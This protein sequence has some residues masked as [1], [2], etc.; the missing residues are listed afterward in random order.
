MGVIAHTSS[1]IYNTRLYVQYS[2]VHI[3][4]HQFC[5]WQHRS[6]CTTTRIANKL[7]HMSSQ[8]CHLSFHETNNPHSQFY[9]SNTK[10]HTPQQAYLCHQGDLTETFEHSEYHERSHSSPTARFVTFSNILVAL[11]SCA[12]NIPVIH[13][14]GSLYHY[15]CNWH[16]AV[17]IA[18]QTDGM[19]DIR[20]PL[21]TASCTCRAVSQMET[22]HPKI[23]HNV[24][25]QTGVT[26]VTAIPT[27]LNLAAVIFFYT[28]VI[29]SK[30]WTNSKDDRN[31]TQQNGELR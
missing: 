30:H 17:L 11:V 18:N 7:E 24:V 23:S 31:G 12:S 4:S 13:R 10:V 20:L 16:S 14:R 8:T 21:C 29:S 3:A 15:Y 22:N 2:T 28:V 19:F 6:T 26:N 1:S 9:G 25:P 5:L 27:P